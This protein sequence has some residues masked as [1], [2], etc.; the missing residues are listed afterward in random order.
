MHG[1]VCLLS[2]YLSNL[3][4]GE[5]LDELD[6]TSA[7]SSDNIF[8]NQNSLSTGWK[9]TCALINH[10]DSIYSNYSSELTSLN[11]L[12][13]SY[14][15]QLL[16]YYTATNTLINNLFTTT[17]ITS[18][19]PSNLTTQIMS[20]SESEFS[21]RTNTSLIGGKIYNDFSN[22]LKTNVESLNSTIKTNINNFI[23]NNIYGKSMKDAYDNFA[24]FDSTV[25]T[26]A[27]VMNKNILDMKDYFLTLQFILMFFTWGYLFF[28]GCLIL[29]Y[30]IYICKHYGILWYFIIILVHLLLVMMLVEIFMSSFFGQVRLICHEVPRAMN[31]IFTGSY[32]VSGN[33]ESYPAK[34]GTG[35]ANMTKMFTTCLSGDGNLI[36]LFISSSDLTTITNLRSS[37]ASLYTNVKNIVDKSNVITNNYDILENSNIFK[38]IVKLET[39]K[40]NLYMTTEGLGEDDIYTILSNI[41]TNLDLTTC[42]MTTEYYV[43]RAADCPSGSVQLT[44]IYNTTGTNH[45]YVI[46]NL[47]STASASYVNA[48]CNN[49]YI[50]AAITYIKELDTLINT[51]LTT[52]ESLQNSYSTAFNHLSTEVESLSNRINSTYEQIN[53]NFASSS[54]ANCGS[55]KFDLIDFCDFIGDTTEYD[56]R[57]VVIFAAFVGVF[58]YV[59]LYA[60]LVV[61]NTLEESGGN[62]YVDDYGYNYGDK[63]LRNININV[64]KV[65]SIKRETEYSDEEE[66]EDNNYNKKIK[67]N[68]KENAQN[69]IGQNIEMTNS[70]QDNEDSDSS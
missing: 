54:L 47:E 58:G 11:S 45:C 22:Y 17:Y 57:I 10:Y 65:K 37:V 39:M 9:G 19:R 56:A 62:R 27:N 41:R 40:Q 48:D 25:A 15:T 20:K 52:L 64:H 3:L 7:S 60:F 18:S 51:R 30:I 33:S 68:K 67:Q 66:E 13:T 36:N 29:L 63:K 5:N 1:S 43:V 8:S 4:N 38:G 70:A 32:I 55:S 69:K 34:F 14:H 46:Q 61:L 49:A 28:F 6:I 16:S 24:N 53:S 35:N 21:D 44:T 12:I 59:M 50:N 26:A 2:R 31:F 23:S 42:N